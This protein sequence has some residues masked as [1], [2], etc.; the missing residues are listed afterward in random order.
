MSEYGVQAEEADRQKRAGLY[1][2]IGPGA[3]IREP[4]EITEAAAARQL[5]QARKLSPPP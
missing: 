2:D 3:R 5:D 4:A 1:V